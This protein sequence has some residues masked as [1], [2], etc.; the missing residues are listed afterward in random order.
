MIHSCAKIFNDP[1]RL[2][3]KKIQKDDQGMYQ[4]FV[5]NEWEQIQSTSELQLGGESITLPF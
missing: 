1:P 5:T 2:V 3:I 4:C